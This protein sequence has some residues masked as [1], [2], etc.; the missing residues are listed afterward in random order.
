MNQKF[1]KSYYF[2]KALSIQGR[3]LIQ[4]LTSFIPVLAV[5]REEVA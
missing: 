1:L 3:G 4:C 5:K 2:K